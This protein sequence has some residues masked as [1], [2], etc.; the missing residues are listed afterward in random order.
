[1]LEGLQLTPERRQYK[2][3][4]A[5]RCKT[6]LHLSGRPPAGLC[7][8]LAVKGSQAAPAEQHAEGFPKVRAWLDPNLAQVTQLLSVDLPGPQSL[9]QKSDH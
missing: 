1:M 4:H 5:N 8:S 3:Q 2:Q 6:Q 9:P 7:R